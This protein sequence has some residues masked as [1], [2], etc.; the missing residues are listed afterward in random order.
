MAALARSNFEPNSIKVKAKSEAPPLFVGEFSA[1]KTLQIICVDDCS[2]D[3]T[4]DILRALKAKGLIDVL[5]F[6]EVNRGKG[7]AIRYAMSH[8]ALGWVLVATTEHGLC[9][10]QLGDSPDELS[11]ALAREFSEAELF[12][13]AVSLEGALAAIRTLV[14]GGSLG[15]GLGLDV[16]GTIFQRRVWEHL[17]SIPSGETRT[18]TQVAEAIGQP[19]AVRAVARACAS[20]PVAL[21]TPCHR[22]VRSDGALA[23]YRWGEHRKQAL[24]ELEAEG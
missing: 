1:G 15:R 10:V 16:Q 22:V 21:V 14:A 11:A 6:H 3:G 24:L 23:G 7:A 2:R 9:S 20:N 8:T 19:A 13:D 12:E 5:V 18:Y 17:R 4:A